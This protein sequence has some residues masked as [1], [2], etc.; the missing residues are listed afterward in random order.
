MLS[1]F[2]RVRLC[3]PM[4]CCLPI[5][6]VHGILQAR[7]LEWVAMP[8]SRGSSWPRDLTCVAYVYC[9]GGGFFTTSTTCEAQFNEY[10][11]PHQLTDGTSTSIFKTIHQLRIQ[12]QRQASEIIAFFFHLWDKSLFL[13][14]TETGN[15]KNLKNTACKFAF[16]FISS[17]TSHVD[18]VF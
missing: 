4:D 11:T 13:L 6:S 3:D 17:K 14:T 9:I 5:P 15:F 12:L 1:H 16:I 18:T 8:S 10:K 2:S 7:I